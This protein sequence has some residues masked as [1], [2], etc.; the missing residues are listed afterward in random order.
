MPLEHLKALIALEESDCQRLTSLI[1][2]I[3]SKSEA[4]RA[5]GCDPSFD[6]HQLAAF[7]SYL[8]GLYS[9]FEGVLKAVADHLEVAIPQTPNW[10]AE[11][12]STFGP[13]AATPGL[14]IISDDL[15]QLLD[16]LRA[17]RHVFRVHYA[18]ELE[19][20]RMRGPVECAETTT[21]LFFES[22]NRF[23]QTLTTPD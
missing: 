7:G 1:R 19:W 2:D 23:V 12:L 16:E 21:V 11:L 4:A 15:F 9:A 8:H 20:R 14:R 6:V 3:Q 13:T 18:F 5:P 22:I 10:H 17:F